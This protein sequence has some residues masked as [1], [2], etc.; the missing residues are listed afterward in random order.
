MWEPKPNNFAVSR[1]IFSPIY[2]FLGRWM[3]AKIHSHIGQV[4]ARPSDRA[5]YNIVGSADSTF[6]YKHPCESLFFY[7]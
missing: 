4:I 1:V 7:M 2:V 5:I 6:F 3:C